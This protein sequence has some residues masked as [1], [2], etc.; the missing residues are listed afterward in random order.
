MEKVSGANLGIL[1]NRMN[2][3]G[4]PLD[5]STLI[6]E[7]DPLD[8]GKTL[9]GHA[10]SSW[11]FREIWGSGGSPLRRLRVR[12]DSNP[13]EDD[14]KIG[15]HEE[16]PRIVLATDKAL[17]DPVRREG[18]SVHLRLK[19]KSVSDS[20]YRFVGH[21]GKYST[22]EWPSPMPMPT[23]TATT[24]AGSQVSDARSKPLVEPADQAP[25]P[26]TVQRAI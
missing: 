4:E 23:P 12:V 1:L 22:V 7:T 26:P 2:E 21:E 17:E 9:Y 19:C 8:F 13:D 24:P 14:P 3:G 16:S 25:Q 11:D 10:K 6:R 20:R 15:L 18:T 5:F